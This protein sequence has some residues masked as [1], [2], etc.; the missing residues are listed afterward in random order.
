MEPLSQRS[1]AAVAATRTVLLPEILDLR[2][3]AFWLRCSRS[4]ARARLRSGEIP[5]RRLGRRWLITRT[6]LLR[7]LEAP[8]A[9]GRSTL[10]VVHKDGGTT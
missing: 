9:A 6:A 8:T 1:T 2:D 4:T 3:L 7:A 10:R 5:G